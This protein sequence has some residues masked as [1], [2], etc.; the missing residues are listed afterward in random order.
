[1]QILKILFPVDAGRWLGRVSFA[2]ATEPDIR[3]QYPPPPARL[4]PSYACFNWR[5][6]LEVGDLRPAAVFDD[7]S[8]L[9]IV[10]L[11]AVASFGLQ[12]MVLLND[13]D[14]ALTEAVSRAQPGSSLVR[15]EGKKSHR[16]AVVPE[17]DRSFG[18]RPG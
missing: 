11:D 6:R 13:V 15:I 16:I 4:P 9:R 1:M 8:D 18:A 2:W 3:W 10:G 14:D 17:P 5:T 7:V 12:P